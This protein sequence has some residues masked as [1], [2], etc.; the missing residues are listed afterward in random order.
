[1]YFT[2]GT[3]IIDHGHGVSSLYAHLSAL[4]VAPGRRVARGERIGAVGATGRVTGAHLHWGMTWRSV[5]VDPGLVVPP[6]PG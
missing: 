4:D 1:M 3:L 5:H 2:G 6:M